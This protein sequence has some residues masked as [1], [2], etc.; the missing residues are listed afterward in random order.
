MQRY[1]HVAPIEKAQR[2]LDTWVIDNTQVPWNQR[3]LW[4]SNTEYVVKV[5]D[6]IELVRAFMW[7]IEKIKASWY[8]R[9]APWEDQDYIDMRY[10]HWKLLW[11]IPRFVHRYKIEEFRAITFDI[12]QRVQDT[13]LDMNMIDQDDGTKFYFE[14]ATHLPVEMKN[15][16]ERDIEE[17][18]QNILWMTPPYIT[19]KFPEWHKDVFDRTLQSDSKVMWA[20]L[21]TVKTK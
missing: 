8:T 17:V 19:R 4:K 18:C 20:R 14:S 1:L 16:K 13:V 9:T 12:S 5:W 3:F 7:D 10:R 15:I 21:G 11:C 6:T 2:I